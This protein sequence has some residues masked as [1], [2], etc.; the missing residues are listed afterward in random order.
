MK[1]STVEVLRHPEA[2]LKKFLHSGKQRMPT[3]TDKFAITNAKVILPD[4]II[5]RGTVVIKAKKIV[6]IG[7]GSSVPRGA[8]KIDARG[9][10]VASGFI[11]LHIHGDVQQ[12]S[13]QQ[14]RGGTTG[15]LATL[16]P[17]KPAALL[18]NIGQVLAQRESASGAKILGIRLEG[19]FLNRAFCGALSPKLLRRPD[20]FE[21]KRIIRKAR[22]AL[23]M[24]VLAP[25]LK[26]APG[27]IRLLSRH[28]IVA[29]LGHTGATYEQALKGI[30]AG[31]THATHTF[32]RM[33]GFNQ[34]A[35]GALGAALTDNRLQCEVIPEKH[36]LHPAALKLL[37]TSKGLDKI[38]LVT[39]STQAQSSP[40]KK[41]SGDVFR[42]KDGTLYGTALTLNKALQ[43]AMKFLGLPIPEAVRL[44]TL[45][46]AKVL[47]IDRR[48]GS[49]V[50]GKDAD[51]VIFDK[52]FKVK[53]TIAEGQ[54]VFNCLQNR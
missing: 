20:I 43:N 40:Y 7:K 50:V 28:H 11:D 24:V 5:P 45:N 51:I 35:P 38:M 39:D 29:S 27:L 18:E 3:D 17:D 37:L 48:K 22:G 14:A 32:N 8:R 49:I 13:L 19:P 33:R 15:F 46:P 1:K 9:N 34:H 25:E 6:A 52:H 44:L 42:L 12:V 21:A 4:K 30:T 41:R 26:G 53:T 10:F 54:I 36:H 23:K 16:H 2:M 47:N 31:L